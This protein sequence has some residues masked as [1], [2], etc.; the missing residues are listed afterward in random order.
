[1]GTS[2]GTVHGQEGKETKIM[3]NMVIFGLGM[4]MGGFISGFILSL[5]MIHRHLED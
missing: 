2:E 3:E 1:M 4:L 5:V